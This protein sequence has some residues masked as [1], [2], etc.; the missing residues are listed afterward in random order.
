MTISITTNIKRNNQHN[1]S[2]VK[3]SVNY[4]EC[5]KLVLHA[6]YRYAECLYAECRGAI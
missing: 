2:V 6:E 3:R 1:R 4:A 5:H